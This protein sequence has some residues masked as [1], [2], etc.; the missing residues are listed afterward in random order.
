MVKRFKPTQKTASDP[1]KRWLTSRASRH[2]KTNTVRSC[3]SEAMRKQVGLL[4]C[5]RIKI[6]M[7]YIEN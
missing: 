6:S 2:H 7:A 1:M 4:C 5:R 3:S